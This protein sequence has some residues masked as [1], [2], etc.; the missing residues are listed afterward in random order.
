M[1]TLQEAF[2]VGSHITSAGIYFNQAVLAF[3]LSGHP[4]DSIREQADAWMTHLKEIGP[5]FAE[6]IQSA[7]VISE[8]FQVTPPQAPSLPEEYPEWA[9]QL[10]Q[11]LLNTWGEDDL[12][13]YLYLYGFILGELMTTL[14]VL[15]SSMDFQ[16][17]FAI[18][19]HKQL[20]SNLTELN[21]ILNRLNDIANVLAQI[22]PLRPFW[23]EFK[24]IQTDIIEIQSFDS[25]N[26]QE[27]LS[28]EL[29]KIE[30]HEEKLSSEDNT[31]NPDQDTDLA[32]YTKLILQDNQ[33]GNILDK[34]APKYRVLAD[35]L[36]D[37]EVALAKILPNE[38]DQEDTN[39][40][41]SVIE[42]PES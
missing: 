37:I 38:D 21:Q 17:S 36:S 19:Y 35:K 5:T 27:K 9:N 42:A 32:F 22:E 1:P 31:E 14:S 10:H 3:D 26:L 33:S 23:R 24:K 11:D 13:R 20:Q 12:E 39:D 16:R 28:E 30:E 4:E 18:P 15:C 40:N 34:I 25:Q 29:S 41:S 6:I 2:L 8:R 7:N